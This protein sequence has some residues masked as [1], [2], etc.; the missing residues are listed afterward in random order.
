[1]AAPR[2]RPETSSRTCV[3]P[4]LPLAFDRLARPINPLLRQLSTSSLSLALRILDRR[5]L[6]RRHSTRA[7]SHRRA[8]PSL[9][10]GQGLLGVALRFVGLL[11]LYLRLLFVVG[12]AV[13]LLLLSEIVI[14]TEELLLEVVGNLT[15]VGGQSVVKNS[16]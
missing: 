6:L 12:S 9:K 13:V 7:R 8:L 4:L 3:E 5:L 16:D 10:L 1:M 15:V 11:L 14:V 2:L